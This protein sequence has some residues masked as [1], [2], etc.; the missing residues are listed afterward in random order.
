MARHSSTMAP[1]YFESMFRETDDP[2]D[3]ETSEYEQTKFEHSVKALS[4]RRYE[5]GF[6]VGCA[7]GVLTRKLAPQ[8]TILL[9]IDVSDTALDAARRRNADRA[10]IA[11]ER[12][13][14]PQEAPGGRFDL[15]ILS[16]VVYYWDDADLGRAADWL[17]SHLEP[18]GDLLLVHFTGDTD[19]PQSGDAAVK[20]LLAALD[21]EVTVVAS[22]R[23]P[24]YR[25]DL[26]RRTA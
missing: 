26:W 24:R 13:A 18:G 16:E 25:L 11:F 22:D 20:K 1:D 5:R 8:C 14:F 21:G 15:V 2:W 9:A 10:T 6:E 12:M 19:Y 23:Q 3:L 7:K 17:T 4:E